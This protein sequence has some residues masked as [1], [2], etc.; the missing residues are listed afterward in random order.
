MSRLTLSLAIACSILL[1]MV[2][3]LALIVSQQR[4][5]IYCAHRP[6]N[7]TDCG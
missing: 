4:E 3:Y 5:E 7:A 1:A 6:Y 2:G